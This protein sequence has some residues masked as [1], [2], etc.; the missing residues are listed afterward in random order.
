VPDSLSLADRR[1]CARLIC[2]QPKP[3]T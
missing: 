3:G 1:P 2:F